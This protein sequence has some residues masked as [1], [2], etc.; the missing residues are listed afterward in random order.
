MALWLLPSWPCS[1]FVWKQRFH[2]DF[3]VST[4]PFIFDVPLP[5]WRA[6]QLYL[7]HADDCVIWIETKPLSGHD[8]RFSFLR[9]VC[10]VFVCLCHANE[11]ANPDHAPLYCP[12]GLHGPEV[13]CPHFYLLRLSW[14][15]IDL[16]NFLVYQVFLLYVHYMRENVRG[17]ILLLHMTAEL[18][19]RIYRLN[20]VYIRWEISWRFSSGL[21][22]RPRSTSAKQLI[23][24]EG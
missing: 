22:S 10:K 6:W 20:D 19:N 4:L 8:R 18:I 17:S 13:N 11:C 5:S 1:F 14:H 24:N 16:I 2:R 7:S 9:S 15:C 3:L 12:S 23:R 21:R